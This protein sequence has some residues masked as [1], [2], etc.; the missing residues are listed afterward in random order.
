[1]DYSLEKCNHQNQCYPFVWVLL[2]CFKLSFLFEFAKINKKWKS[3][4]IWLTDVN[5][6]VNM[7]RYRQT[8]VHS[9]MFPVIVFKLSG[10][11]LLVA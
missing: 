2:V 8:K 7:E 5:Y 6:A 10:R 9:A 11:L 4:R 3:D 1:M